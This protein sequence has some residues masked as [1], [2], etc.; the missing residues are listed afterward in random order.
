MRKV[1][2]KM[3]TEDD[4]IRTVTTAYANG[5]R[6]VKLY[7]M[8]GLP[9]ETDEDVL[10]IA[11]MAKRV[12]Q[13][14]R[15]AHRDAATSAARSRSAGSCPSR[16]R[17]SSGRPSATTRPSTGGCGRCGTRSAATRSTAGRSASATT[18]A[19]PRSSRACCRAAT[20]GSARSSGAVW[21]DGGRFDGWSEHFSYERWMCRADKALEGVDVDWYTAPRARR[22]RGAA[23]GPPRRRARP[24][25]ALAG[26][27]GRGRRGRGRG[28]PLDA[29]LRLRRLPD[30]GTEIQIGPTGKKLLPLTVV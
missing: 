6:Q 10:E 4:L 12:I 17:R 8:C 25:V 20:A 11:D 21:E 30:H 22:G 29:V 24:R 2:N 26:L 23:L 18:T 19:S 3:V 9:T 27:A 28:L 16:T 15:E 1:I 13:A 14:G 7:F 5:W